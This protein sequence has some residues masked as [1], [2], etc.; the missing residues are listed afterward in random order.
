MQLVAELLAA[1]QPDLAVLSGD[2]VSGFACTN[3]VEEAAAATE[4]A[5]RYGGGPF[6]AGPGAQSG[7]CPPGWLEAAW[8]AATAPLRAAGVPW[9]VTLGNHD[10]EADVTDRR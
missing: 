7:T 1:E 4:K 6:T 9:A 10:A 5:A 8:A 3:T 2:I